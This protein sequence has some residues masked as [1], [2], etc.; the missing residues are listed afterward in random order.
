M[1]FIK[2]Q[3]HSSHYSILQQ[4]KVKIHT[5]KQG[6]LVACSAGVNNYFLDTEMVSLVAMKNCKIL[7]LR[8]ILDMPKSFDL[9]MKKCDEIKALGGVVK[10]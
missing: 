3:N 1:N 5:K 4:A 7:S 2:N 9:I 10:I 8:S 6:A